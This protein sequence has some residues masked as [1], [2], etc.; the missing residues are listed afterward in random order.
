MTKENLQE[1]IGEF[2]KNSRY[3]IQ[4][5]TVSNSAWGLKETVSFSEEEKNAVGGVVA[6]LPLVHPDTLTIAELMQGLKPISKN[7]NSETY[8]I[9][10][11]GL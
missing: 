7:G 6:I 4:Y 10:E 11:L 5:F 1:I 2:V 9:S 3:K 8:H